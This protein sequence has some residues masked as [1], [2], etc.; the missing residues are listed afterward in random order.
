MP[1]RFVLTLIRSTTNQVSN[2]S[3]AHGILNG[4]APVPGQHEDDLHGE[5]EDVEGGSI[6]GPSDLTSA[7][8]EEP[9]VT[10]E[11][12]SDSASTKTPE[13]KKKVKKGGSK[14]TIQ[15]RE[16][17]PPHPA[18][19][20]FDFHTSKRMANPKSLRPGVRYVVDRV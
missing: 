16:R 8:S 7:Y 18:Q 4:E 15:D 17:F 2:V 5:G 14:Y 20:L 11:P 12:P 13:T 9:I 19:D 10:S 6:T 3:K 1:S